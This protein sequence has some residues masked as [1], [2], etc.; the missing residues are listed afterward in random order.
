MGLSAF[1]LSIL[2][3]MEEMFE[4]IKQCP[5]GMVGAPYLEIATILNHIIRNKVAVWS[6]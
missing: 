1:G 4:A 3:N 2:T 5:G 6:C